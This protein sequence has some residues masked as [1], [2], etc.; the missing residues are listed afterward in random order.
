MQR[1]PVLRAYLGAGIIVDNFAGGGGVSEAFVR[2][3]GRSPDHAV[4]H[5]E[6]ALAMHARNHPET[7]HHVADV[8]DIDPAKLCAGRRVAAVAHVEDP[9]GR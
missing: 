7:Q 4:N 8:W 3:L 6:E 1:A 9:H 2:A 5:D